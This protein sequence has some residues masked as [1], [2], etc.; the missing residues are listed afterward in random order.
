MLG[1][2]DWRDRREAGGAG[3]LVYLLG[4]KCGEL[5]RQG[6]CFWMVGRLVIFKQD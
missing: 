2:D 4:G 5:V 3:N 6:C 1:I